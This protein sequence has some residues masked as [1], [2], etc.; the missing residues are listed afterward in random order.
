MTNYHYTRYPRGGLPLAVGDAEFARSTAV[1]AGSQADPGPRGPGRRPRVQPRPP[2]WTPGRAAARARLPRAPERRPRG[3]RVGPAV[4][5]TNTQ[6]RAGPTPQTPGH[7][8]CRGADLTE[9]DATGKQT[10]NTFGP[11]PPGRR[12]PTRSRSPARAGSSPSPSLYRARGLE[13]IPR[14]RRARARTSS[15]PCRAARGDSGAPPEC[16]PHPHGSGVLRA[17]GPGSPPTGPRARGVLPTGAVRRGSVLPH[18]PRDPRPR[19]TRGASAPT[20]RA[21]ESCPQGRA[22]ELGPPPQA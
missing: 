15:I 14:R 17:R 5:E 1:K 6:A 22:R 11:A 13:S 10:G 12:G 20:P 8:S 7:R 21:R 19:A 9:S 3:R 2:S 18:G 4:A 16:G